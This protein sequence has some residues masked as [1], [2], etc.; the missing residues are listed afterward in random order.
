MFLRIFLFSLIYGWFSVNCLAPVPPVYRKAELALKSYV[1]NPSHNPVI[2]SLLNVLIHDKQARAFISDQA[3][4]MALENIKELDQKTK[5]R[6]EQLL[7]QVIYG[8]NCKP[9]GKN[10][11][12]INGR[13]INRPTPD[14][15]EFIV[16][17]LD[18]YFA[19][20]KSD[21]DWPIIADNGNKD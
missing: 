12:S 16:V 18:K 7:S 10:C 15:E 21:E 8:I 20:A 1:S 14:L 11:S 6:N 9:N 17:A 4:E 5:T 3:I 13:K 19:N 2:Y